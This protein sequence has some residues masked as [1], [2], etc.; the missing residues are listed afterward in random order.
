MLLRYSCLVA[1]VLLAVIPA[2][3]AGT[4]VQTAALSG[5]QTTA[6][7]AAQ[8][9]VLTGEP[10]PA[11]LA[12]V[13]GIA[14]TSPQAR[15]GD[16]ELLVHV[17]EGTSKSV[18][19]LPSDV[20]VW[21]NGAWLMAN[22]LAA[23]SSPPEIG[24]Y[25]LP[26]QPSDMQVVGN[27][28]YLALRK[29]QGLLIL[30]YSIPAA[31]A[32]IGTLPG[33]DLLSVAVD[34]SRAYCGRGSSGVLVVD[35]T[36][37]TA[38][39]AITTFDTPGSANGTDIAG[40]ILYV[41]MGTSGL[42]IY[43][44]TDPLAPV[45]LATLTTN[46]FCTYVQE[47]DGL[48]FACD[49]NGLRIFDVAMPALPTLLGVYSAG[50]TCYEMCFTANANVIYLAGLPG[51]FALMIS[52]PTNPIALDAAPIGN[53]FSCA[54]GDGLALLTSRYTGLH[55]LDG[56]FT[57]LA[58]LTNGGFSM[59]LHLYGTTLYVA[60]LSGGVRIYDLSVPEA[61][62]FLGE[63][64]TDPNCQ[65]LAVAAG[66]LYAVNSNN[67]GAGLTLT[68][69][70][71]PATPVPLSE[72]N[73]AN[74]TMGLGLAGDLCV[75]ANGFGGLR[76]VNVA[77]PLAPALLGDLA[78]GAN[79]VDVVPVGE[80]AFTISFGGGMLAVDIA[81]PTNLTI[82]SQQLWGFLNALDVTGDL[83]WVADGQLGLR[84]VDISD[85]SNLVSLAT[86]GIGGQPRDVVR[87][88]EDDPYV[89]LADDFY[90]LRQMDVSDP[91]DP[92]LFGSYASADRGMG[93]D[94]LGGLVVLAAGETGVYVYRNPAAVAVQEQPETMPT[95]PATPA[96]TAAPNPFNPRL[97]VSYSLP[98]A[99]SVRIDVFD[100]RGRHV[101]TL[102]RR[103][104][105]AG[106]GSLIW[107]GDDDNGRPAASGVYRLR[108]VT[109]EAVTGRSVTLV[110]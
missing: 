77:D 56:N 33:Y 96:L 22:D 31:P 36:D 75:L 97:V 43:D 52:D 17:A 2:Q 3:A 79:V 1:A 105:P 49:G 92:I 65:D 103:N 63:V 80:V 74:Q 61:P 59:K 102:L 15:D 51:L 48:A 44:V 64:D 41:A 19:R 104:A 28:V 58:N 66:T 27:T 86:Q 62:I 73:T 20:V 42:G 101:R 13:T 82:I 76:T 7:T 93:V 54:A 18:R 57:P 39:T 46:G 94:T 87:S 5:A 91:T 35:L 32:V 106:T 37:P 98:R 12:D 107:S 26:A 45:S 99:G 16:L 60:D 6:Q 68:D 34:G 83:A 9:D 108:L 67:S 71:D 10:I 21:Q 78:I 69:V 85:P 23:P 70:T 95:V 109:D 4:D 29:A 8:I 84:V 81:D 53:S 11:P 14:P 25:L 90:G 110:R 24:R 100:A 55:I 30:D 89:Y 72:F 88:R 38:P 47:R 50:N 40:N